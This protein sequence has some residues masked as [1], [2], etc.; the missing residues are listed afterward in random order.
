MNKKLIKRNSANIA[1]KRSSSLQIKSQKNNYKET[2]VETQLEFKSPNNRPTSKKIN[3][4]NLQ[5][6]QQLSNLEE[7]VIN[8]E[9]D[10]TNLTKNNNF[11]KVFLNILKE[12]NEKLDIQIKGFKEKMISAQ[13]M[14]NCLFNKLNKIKNEFLFS[15]TE[16]RINTMMKENK[17]NQVMNNVHYLKDSNEDQKNIFGRKIENELVN[18]NNT[19]KD[20]KKVKYQ[21]NLMKKCLSKINEKKFFE[22]ENILKERNEMEKFLNEL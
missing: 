12:K 5:R 3:D 20:L 14:K 7:E 16:F 17:I 13:K 8:I 21:I 11:N 1:F 2:T 22:N 19:E 6:F 10:N 18:K 15:Q 4:L 9:K